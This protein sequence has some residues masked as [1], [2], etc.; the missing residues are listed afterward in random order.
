MTCA[1]HTHCAP[2]LASGIDFIFG[3]PIPADQRARI[4]RYTRELT[5]AMEKVALQ[6]LAARAP[7]RLSWGQGTVAFAA[8]RRVLKKGKWV[9]FG[10]NPNGPV[11]HTLPV[12]RVTDPA[13]KV[14]RRAR[15]LR[16]PLHD[17]GRRV[18]QDLRRVG[19]LRLRRDRAAASRRDRTGDHR[20]R[21]GCQPRA[22]AE[23]RRREEPRGGPGERDRPPGLLVADS[24]ARP[25]DGAVPASRASPGSPPRPTGPASSGPS[26]LVRRGCSL[27]RYSEN[28]IGENLCHRR[29]PTLSRP[30]AL[31]TTWPWS[32]W[33]ARW[34]S[35]MHSG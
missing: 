25:H 27:A 31:G 8:N 34:L 28:W 1:T 7:G 24:P 2:A 12:L 23:S 10:V 19:R 17:P 18:Q 20:L 32:S 9:G 26:S 5:D 33:E 21:G 22:P 15:E 29:S 13:G 6:A 14:A 11:D 16:L 35:I 30:G 4:D 3:K